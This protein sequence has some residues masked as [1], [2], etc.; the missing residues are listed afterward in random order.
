MNWFPNTHTH[1][2]FLTH[3]GRVMHI[4]IIK[5]NHHWFRYW[6]IAWPAPSHYLNQSWNIVNWDPG[7]QISLKFSSKYNNFHSTKC[8]WKG[9][10]N[11]GHFVLASMCWRFLHQLHDKFNMLYT[12]KL[13]GNKTANNNFLTYNGE[14][15]YSIP[16]VTS[17]FDIL[18]LFICKQD[19][20]GLTHWGRD[21]MAPILQVIFSNA[22]SWVKMYELRLKFHCNLF[23][24]V[25][26]TIF[27]HW[28]R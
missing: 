15:I 26:L 25:L 21:K 14:I 11:G 12:T 6:L 9:L 4:C 20:P 17:L 10:E 28:F 16:K 19:T 5:L 1:I 24:R 3:W 22:F 8:I 23:L 27:Q 13:T 7:E 18:D 2:Y